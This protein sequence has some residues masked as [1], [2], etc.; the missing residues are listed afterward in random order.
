MQQSGESVA[1]ITQCRGRILPHIATVHNSGWL[2][3]IIESS[4]VSIQIH[5]IH[6]QLPSLAKPALEL[7]GELHRGGGKLI[8]QSAIEYFGIGIATKIVLSWLGAL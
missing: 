5:Y 8:A 6:R 4:H 2:I 3:K 1:K 7:R